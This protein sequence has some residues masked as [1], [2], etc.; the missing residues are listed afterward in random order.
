MFTD[1]GML[2][3]VP[4][5]CAATLAEA[6]TTTELRDSEPSECCRYPPLSKY[7]KEAHVRELEKN[8]FVVVVRARRLD[9]G[10]ASGR[11]SGPT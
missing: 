11:R 9:Q 8:G 3:A 5:V 6:A 1:A 10:K 7:L 4:F 2:A